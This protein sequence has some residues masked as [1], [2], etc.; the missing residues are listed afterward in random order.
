M[1]FTSYAFT[2]FLAVVFPLYYLLPKRFQQPLLFAASYAFYCA[3]GP[4]G[5]LCILTE[6]VC[7]YLAACAMDACAKK[8][9]KRKFLIAGVFACL[10]TLAAV[11]YAG[12]V[13][14]AVNALLKAAGMPLIG[15]TGPVMPLGVSF[16]TFQALGYLIDVYRGS[17]KAE[18]NI[19]KVSLFLSFF[20]LLPQGPVCRFGDMEKTLFKEHRFDPEGFSRGLQRILWGYFKKL[21]IADRVLIASGTII[22]DPASYGGGFVFSGMLFYALGL[23][24]D[25][26]G[27]IDITI[28]IAQALGIRVKE[29]FDRP[30]FSKSVKEYWRRWHISMGAWF[31][32][33]IFYPVSVCRPMLRFS[34]FARRKFGN[35]VGRKLPVYLSSLAVWLATGIWHGAGWNFIVWGLGNW[36]IIMVS[37][38]LSPLYERFH[39]R[40]HV[41]GKV[42][43]KAF[44][45]LRT[46]LLMSCLRMLD[47]YRNVPLTF[48]MFFS[49]F[50]GEGWQAM[51][52]GGLMG[53]GLTVADYGV[54]ILGVVVLV[55]V[56]L[57]QRHG[58]V[59]GRI[60]RLPYPVRAAVW[61]GLF[62]AV[63]LA[64][65]YGTAYI[66]SQFIYGQY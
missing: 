39:S 50:T 64:G 19:L 26:T 56:S 29:N 32:D 30:Y 40:F 35:T 58:S 7:S 27:G 34:R 41:Q 48:R 42:W 17:E 24:G 62:V 53:L 63:L 18:K 43:F 15:A 33:Y 10:G 22:G 12:P 8:G 46:M 47:C 20:P 65:E 3:G 2:G 31:T 21:V 61:F 55:S 23:Y 44:Q 14:S 57:I 54:L 60:A 4:L 37:Q 49:M 36:L 13:L 6:T 1:L 59:R 16:Y 9:R 38:E 45:A 11:K 25:F 28:G 5:L 52:H 66:Q 51:A